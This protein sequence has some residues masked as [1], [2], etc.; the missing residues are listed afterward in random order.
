MDLHEIPIPYAPG[1]P[2]ALDYH[3]VPVDLGSPR[4]MEPLVNVSTLG[5]AAESYYARAD[6]L[7]PPYY[8]RFPAAPAHVWCRHGVA[9]KLQEVNRVVREYGVELLLWDGYRPINCQRELWDHFIKLARQILENS[10]EEEC[11][12]F[13]GQ[14][15]SDPRKFKED[16]P[17]T[18]PTH[19]TGGAV[20]LTLRRL[21][22]GELLYMG[23]IFDDASEISHTAYYEC[24]VTRLTS[25]GRQIPSSFKEALRN[26]RLLY[27]A[28][29]NAGFANYSY[30]WW[31]YDWG[32]QM[33]ITNRA[34]SLPYITQANVAWYGPA[35]LPADFT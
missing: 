7:N 20:D 25:E 14:Y 12:K 24:E 27:W 6:S 8:R 19:I 26:R 4:S 35:S 2:T 17:H 11:T 22:S 15:C 28:M 30:E 16:D 34:T 29:T 1:A 32:T 10:N 5:I 9:E 33:W 23:G 18:W 3:S 13:A 31:H 21:N